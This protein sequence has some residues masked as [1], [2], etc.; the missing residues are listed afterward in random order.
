LKNLPR[1]HGRGQPRNRTDLQ[2]AG[3]TVV[4]PSPKTDPA[5]LPPAIYVLKR[6]TAPNHDFPDHAPWSPTARTI[7]MVIADAID[8]DAPEGEV[9]FL[10][11]KRIAQRSG[12]SRASVIRHLPQLIDGD[13][14]L[15]KQTFPGETKGHA[16]KCARFE[17]IR[18]PVAFTKA[19]DRARKVKQARAKA[20]LGVPGAAPLSREDAE[21]REAFVVS[22]LELQKR[23]REF[24]GDLDDAEYN[25]L[26]AELEKPILRK[27]G[28]KDPRIATRDASDVCQVATQKTPPRKRR[29]S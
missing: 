20:V 24:G 21:A 2:T 14:L 27:V 13:S 26:L 15:F 25:R 12:C 3:N 9:C 5:S 22:K 19:R 6:V 7:A 29:P 8:S 4:K 10:S 18:N 16:H 17:L 11:E 1:P 23:R 28:G